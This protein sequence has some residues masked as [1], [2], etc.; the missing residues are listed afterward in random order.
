MND[1]VWTI[2]LFGAFRRFGTTVDVPAPDGATA[3]ELKRKLAATLRGERNDPNAEGLVS[4]SVLAT[5][6]EVLDDNAV[7]SAGLNL[8]VLPPVSG[9]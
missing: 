8:S 9:G 2:R 5:D 1:V 6:R 7:L 3:G 4:V